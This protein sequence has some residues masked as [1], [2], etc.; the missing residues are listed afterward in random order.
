VRVFRFDLDAVVRVI[1]ARHVA[2]LDELMDR[3]EPT[4]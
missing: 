3:S 4:A 2:G 1:D